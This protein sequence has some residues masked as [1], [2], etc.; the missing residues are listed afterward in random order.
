KAA[1]VDQPNQK[2]FGGFLSNSG[3]LCIATTFFLMDSVILDGHIGDSAR[4]GLAFLLVFL[5]F[6]AVC[7]GVGLLYHANIH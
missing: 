2:W 4:G 1:I 3:L 7:H 6:L 5:G